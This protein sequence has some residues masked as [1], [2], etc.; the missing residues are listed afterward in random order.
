MDLKFSPHKIDKRRKAFIFVSP[1]VLGEWLVHFNSPL[2]RNATI[3]GLPSGAQVDGWEFDA[4]GQVLRFTII[5]E[6]LAIVA[7]ADDVPTITPVF[8]R[9]YRQDLP[10]LPDATDLALIKTI[11][12]T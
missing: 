8:H 5:S 6:E 11:R 1:E 10:N 4:V 2:L 3:T 9:G 7:N 12:L